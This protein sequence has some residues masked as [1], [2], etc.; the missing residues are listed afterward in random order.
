MNPSYQGPGHLLLNAPPQTGKLSAQ[1]TAASPAKRLTY[2]S[3]GVLFAGDHKPKWRNWQTR[4][5]QVLVLVTEGVGSSP[6]FG[7]TVSYGLPVRGSLFL[8]YDLE[9]GMNHER[10]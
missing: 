10:P 5:V 9:K 7:T 8:C 1:V 2:A 6:T 4:Q 3:R